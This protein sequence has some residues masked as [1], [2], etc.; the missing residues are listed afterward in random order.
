MLNSLPA[1]MA[2]YMF[3]S[4]FFHLDCPNTG[5]DSNVINEIAKPYKA[6]AFIKQ[7]RE[8]RIFGRSVRS[9]YIVDPLQV[10]VVGVHNVWKFR[11]GGKSYHVPPEVALVHHYRE[12]KHDRQIRNHRDNSTLRFI[13]ALHQIVTSHSTWT[14]PLSSKC[15]LCL[16]QF[17]KCFDQFKKAY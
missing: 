13:G 12:I 8:E 6:Y 2:A 10:Q 11:K 14:N 1:N 9:K 16:T 15:L 7:Y 3:R 17:P 4:S 5:L